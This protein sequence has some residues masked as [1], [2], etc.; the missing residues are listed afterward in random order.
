M[1]IGVLSFIGY[2]VVMLVST[3]VL[4]AAWTNSDG[5]ANAFNVWWAAILWPVTLLCSIVCGIGL[6]AAPLGRYLYRSWRRSVQRLNPAFREM[7]C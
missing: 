5:E 1:T 6:T 2:I 3:V 4:A 7:K